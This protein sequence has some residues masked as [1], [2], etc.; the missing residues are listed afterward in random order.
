MK[1]FD[2]HC[3]TLTKCMNDNE[4]LFINKKQNSIK[5]LLGFETPVQLFAIFTDDPYIGDAY[6]YAKAAVSFF[7]EQAKKYNE[8]VYLYNNDPQKNRVGAVLTI[9]G[10][11]PVESIA[12]LEEFYELGV[13]LMTLTWNRVNKIGSGMTSGSEDGLTEFGRQAVKYMNRKNMVIDVSHLNLQGFKDV[14]AIS[15]KP[16]IASHSNSFTLC[17]HPRNLRDWQINEI[18]ACGGIIGINLYP[19]FLTE[20]NEADIND[21]LR[22]TEYFLNKGGENMLALGCDF[23]GISCTPKNIEK[24]ADMTIV[25]SAFEKHF[26]RGIADKIFFDNAKNFFDKYLLTSGVNL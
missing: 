13:R 11:E 1:Y 21:I 17:P 6:G 19:P 9:E 3:D 16:F 22:H 24:T 26:G 23:D 14:S 18:A 7:Y 10:G 25:Y 8:Y 2:L 20:D 15:E 5:Q 4:E 12:A